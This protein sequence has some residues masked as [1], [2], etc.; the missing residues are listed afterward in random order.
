[1][2]K[3]WILLQLV[4]EWMASGRGISPRQDFAAL[5][6][7][8]YSTAAKSHWLTAEAMFCNTKSNAL[9]HVPGSNMLI[10]KLSKSWFV[11]LSSA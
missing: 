9:F 3:L 11:F 7:N 2:K 4:I 5:F 6:N 10:Q 8:A 1:M